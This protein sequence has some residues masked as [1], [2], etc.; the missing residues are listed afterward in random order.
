MARKHNIFE[1][2]HDIFLEFW[3]F[4]YLIGLVYCASNLL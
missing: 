1:M 2:I 4:F 3:A